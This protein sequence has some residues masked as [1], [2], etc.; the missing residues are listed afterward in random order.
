MSAEKKLHEQDCVLRIPR[1][2]IRRF[3]GQPR[4]YFDE[5]EMA[6]LVASLN[7]VGQKT[8]I[9]VKRVTDDPSHDYEIVDGERRLIASGIAGLGTLLAWVRTVADADEQFIDSVV[10]NFGRSGHTPL[11]IAAAIDRIRKSKTMKNLSPGEQITRIA[12]IFARSEPWVYYHLSLLK[13]HT[14]VQAMMAPTIPVE[15]RLQQSVAVFIST[16]PPLLQVQ[17]AK[18]VVLEGMTLNQARFYA[19]KVADNAGVEV[20]TAIKSRTP[21]ED[22]KNFRRFVTKTRE[23]VEMFLTPVILENLQKRDPNDLATMM[24]AMERIVAQF[25]TLCTALNGASHPYRGEGRRA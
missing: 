16:L 14:D 2:H 1:A 25:R 8:P 10:G 19:R 15:Q 5:K 22:Y 3:K 4:Q 21:R 11:E 18:T 12:R 20:G 9:V 23:G 7:E 13:L 17:V 6:D 24:A